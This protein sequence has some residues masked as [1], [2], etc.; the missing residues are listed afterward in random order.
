MSVCLSVCLPTWKLDVVVCHGFI[1]ASL[2][3]PCS[4]KQMARLQNKQ[5]YKHTVRRKDGSES[6]NTS[7]TR[8]LPPDNTTV[9]AAPA[10]RKDTGDSGR[11]FCLTLLWYPPS[12]PP[13]FPPS[14]T[15]FKKC[16]P[17]T[18]SGLLTKQQTK[19]ELFTSVFYMQCGKCLL[20]GFHF[21]REINFQWE[22]TFCMIFT[23]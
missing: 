7:T 16:G 14:W 18:A 19:T 13:L 8:W 5:T 9:A 21:S 6:S 22:Q 20:S 1:H 23:S 2:P 12:L 10:P 17:P 15:C 11:A 4:T 3:Q